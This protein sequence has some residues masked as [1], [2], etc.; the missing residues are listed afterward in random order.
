MEG[1]VGRFGILLAGLCVASVGC[2]GPGSPPAGNAPGPQSPPAAPQPSAIPAPVVKPPDAL[3]SHNTNWAGVVADVT[4]LRR[5]G[6]TLTA[7]I[8]LRN[9][10]Q[11]T[12]VVG[13]NLSAV[14]LLDA[15]RGQ[16][17]LVLKDEKDA[18]I[19]SDTGT[20]GFGPD[21]PLTM[22]MKFP[23]PPADVTTVTLVV[24]QM[25]PFEDLAIEG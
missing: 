8:R 16:K 17:Y 24:P 10:M 3:A 7:M 22:W 14:Y 13:F 5:K 18:F 6:N 4:I 2:Q 23:A 19:A 12:A 1:D 25:P 21:A 20:Q 11:Q 9:N 15:A